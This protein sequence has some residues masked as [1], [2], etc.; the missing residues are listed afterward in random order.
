MISS[1]ASSSGIRP[2]FCDSLA[3]PLSD[4]PYANLHLL[5]S[6]CFWSQHRRTAERQLSIKCIERRSGALTFI[7]CS[8][9][10]PSHI[11]VTMYTFFSSC[12][13]MRRGHHAIS[14]ISMQRF[15]FRTSMS[16]AIHSE[17]TTSASKCHANRRTRW[18]RTS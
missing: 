4:R 16:A 9:V 7:Y 11:S 3:M 1:A 12:A 18:E 15:V 6:A 17:V 13:A 14:T 5:V 10:P 2:W 8:S